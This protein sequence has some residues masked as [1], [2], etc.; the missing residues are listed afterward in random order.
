M[1]ND[2]YRPLMKYLVTTR[3]QGLFR[4][5]TRVTDGSGNEVF[6]IDRQRSAVMATFTLRDAQG[7]ALVVLRRKL[8]LS[9]AF[10]I[11]GTGGVLASIRPIGGL[12]AMPQ[13]E[14][15]LATGTVLV[16]PNDFAHGRL[17]V[18]RADGGPFCLIERQR[19][20]SLSSSSFSVEAEPVDSVLAVSVAF[21][22]TTMIDRVIRREA[23]RLLVNGLRG[24][25]PGG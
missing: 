18:R 23:A 12:L 21:C 15:R 14:A 9:D 24:Q 16:A 13:Y 5:E 8:A 11:E 22:L 17:E 7:S 3:R 10:E 6:W 1:R 19:A 2:A 25:R 20:S 4:T